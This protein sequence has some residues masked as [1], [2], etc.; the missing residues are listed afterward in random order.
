M[1]LEFLNGGEA[2]VEPVVRSDTIPEP[3][4][5]LTNEATQVV[6]LPQEMTFVSTDL[7]V[8]SIPII[9]DWLNRV[10]TSHSSII[11]LMVDL[12]M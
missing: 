10:R 11:R 12:D 4:D 7:T 5:V 2:T 1:V 3:A 9:H 8:D 6:D